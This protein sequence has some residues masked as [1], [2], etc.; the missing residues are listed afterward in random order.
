MGP[1]PVTHALWVTGP[2][3]VTHAL[4]GDGPRP[5]H[6]DL[7][8]MGFSRESGGDFGFA[9]WDFKGKVAVKLDSQNQ[10]LK[11]QWR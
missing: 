2:D 6:P 9:E 8:R 4:S 3:P 5:R 10:I 1:D 7:S 11:G